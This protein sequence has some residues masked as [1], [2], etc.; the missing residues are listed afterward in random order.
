MANLPEPVT[1]ALLVAHGRLTRLS[2]GISAAYED[3]ER[4][5]DY[6]DAD[7]LA[8][9]YREAL[10]DDFHELMSAFVNEYPTLFTEVRE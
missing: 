3:A 2:A 5:G 6:S 8:A 9:D 4:N 7:E 1:A 10:H